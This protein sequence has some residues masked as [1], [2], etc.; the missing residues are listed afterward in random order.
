MTPYLEGQRGS[1]QFQDE[2]TSDQFL[3]KTA[4][5]QNQLEIV[6]L[7]GDLDHFY[8]DSGMQD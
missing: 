8:F 4:V 1:E 5:S 7:K 3:P 2:C 6:V